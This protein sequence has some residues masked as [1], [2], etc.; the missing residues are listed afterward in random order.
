M[1][2][3]RINSHIGDGQ[4]FITYFRDTADAAKEILRLEKLRKD[5]EKAT[6][7]PEGYN[8]QLLD[9]EL[10]LQSISTEFVDKGAEWEACAKQVPKCKD[11]AKLMAELIAIGNRKGKK[12]GEYMAMRAKIAQAKAE[13]LA[14][15]ERMAFL[16]NNA[17][18]IEMTSFDAWC[19]DY[20]HQD[21]G[22]IAPN[23]IVGT[24][25]TYGARKTS[26]KDL[27]VPAPQINIQAS[28]DNR[29]VYDID[30]D[31]RIQPLAEQSVATCLL[32]VLEWLWVMSKKPTFATCY[33]NSKNDNTNVGNI[34]C[35]GSTLVSGTPQGFAYPSDGNDGPITLDNVPF[36]YQDCHSKVFEP[37]D[38]VLVRFTGEYHTNPTII[39][40]AQNPKECKFLYIT[41]TSDSG[42]YIYGDSEQRILRGEDGTPVFLELTGN[43]TWFRY[44]MGNGADIS[45][46]F[47]TH[48]QLNLQISWNIVAKLANVID[49]PAT[50][51]LPVQWALGYFAVL[52]IYGVE[53]SLPYGGYSKAF[54]DNGSAGAPTCS[55]V[56]A[57]AFEHILYTLEDGCWGPLPN[58]A[59]PEFFGV[60]TNDP[61]TLWNLTV[62]QTFRTPAS[63]ESPTEPYA[64]QGTA[65]YINGPQSGLFET[66][67][68]IL[69]AV[70]SPPNPPPAQYGRASGSEVRT[71][72][73]TPSAAVEAAGISPPAA[74]KYMILRY[75]GDQGLADA[76]K[77]YGNATW[78]SL[79]YDGILRLCLKLTPL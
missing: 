35:Y 72:Y 32:N 65:V 51:Y 27:Y 36:Y 66:D 64:L 38:W 9:I 67:A 15:L 34:T 78:H 23:T 14:A 6:Y 37:G 25:E 8:D 11:A 47:P 33:L 49:F 69:P 19:I 75:W 60:G 5:L 48:Q 61:H 4:Y 22:P 31:H 52:G 71:G 73:S 28:F 70:L 40:F 39:G 77:L 79:D 2:K 16:Q 24:I 17:T 55:Q 41:Y 26:G 20:P 21:Y 7:K 68:V 1:G 45:H 3:A 56:G 30:R 76:K 29:A 59:M 13:M 46:D 58:G 18:D 63:G 44:W 43:S 12:I 62:D 54:C 10:E 57:T 53:T 74:D 42:G 50:I